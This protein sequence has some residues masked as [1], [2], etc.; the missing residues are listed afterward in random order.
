MPWKMIN[1]VV[2]YEREPNLA[3]CFLIFHRTYSRADNPGELDIPD[4]KNKGRDVQ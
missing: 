3:F 2:S 4:S 1:I